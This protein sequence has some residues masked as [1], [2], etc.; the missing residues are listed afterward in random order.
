MRIVFILSV[1]QVES[2]QEKIVTLVPYFT[3]TSGGFGAGSFFKRQILTVF[4][5]YTVYATCVFI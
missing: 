3:T 5:V 2:S 1:K 4:R